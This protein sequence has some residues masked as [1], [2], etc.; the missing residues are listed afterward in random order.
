MQMSESHDR[1]PALARR[2]LESL[3]A[4]VLEPFLADWA[5]SQ[6][7]RGAPG[8][9]AVPRAA[10]PR[11]GDAPCT[12]PVLRWLPR[13]AAQPRGFGSALVTAL[14]RSAPSL[15]WRQ[16]YT[17]GELDADFMEN[18]GWTEILGPRSCGGGGQTACGLL[19]LGA[20]TFYPPHRHEAEEIY[21][22]LHGAAEWR[23][24]DAVWRRRAPGTLIHHE[25]EES[26]AMRTAAEP[27]LALYLWRSAD[28]CQESRL[29]QR[30]AA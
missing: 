17:S 15:A 14:C 8:R 20:D 16:S 7:S 22:P 9:P 3:A 19:L 27:L 1:L 11:T 25:S 21:V 6:I 12:L 13:I 4:P 24:G 5:G 28:L 30:G 23:Q 29:D 18:Y 2:L 26:H 10:A